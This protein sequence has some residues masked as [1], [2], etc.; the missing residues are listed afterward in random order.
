MRLA[1][2]AIEAGGVDRESFYAAI[3]GIREFRGGADAIRIDRYGD[4]TR[5]LYIR[6]IRDG[7]ISIV[8]R[9]R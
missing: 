1:R 5:N 6:R 8:G 4:S 7:V 3:R 9:Y 2:T